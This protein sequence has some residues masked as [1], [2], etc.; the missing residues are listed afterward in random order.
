MGSTVSE[1]VLEESQRAMESGIVTFLY[2]CDSGCKKSAYGLYTHRIS[3]PPFGVGISN[4]LLTAHSS[5]LTTSP[6]AVNLTVMLLL[7]RPK[8]GM[9]EVDKL[10]GVQRFYI[11]LEPKQQQQQFTEELE[12]A[13]KE[14]TQ[15]H[16]AAAADKEDV[17]GSSM[18]TNTDQLQQEDS[19]TSQDEDAG[20]STRSRKRKQ[21]QVDSHAPDTTHTQAKMDQFVEPADAKKQPPDSHQEADA[22]ASAHSSA[23]GH[24]KGTKEGQEEGVEGRQ[25]EK[26]EKQ[27][28]EQQ[29]HQPQARLLVVPKKR[30]PDGAKHERFYA[31]VGEYLIRA[32]GSVAVVYA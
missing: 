28:Q 2:R 23:A 5:Q 4:F 30:L 8:V 27:E 32:V 25:E 11:L 18:P 14:R 12:S 16:A 29:E 19:K 17:K 22:P 6:P 31:F 20:P 15:D 7:C 1:S 21:Q 10:Q 9:E 3:L 26:E 13:A 24:G